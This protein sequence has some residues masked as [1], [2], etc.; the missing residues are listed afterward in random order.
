M[1]PQS[2]LPRGFDIAPI[3]HFLFGR[4][5]QFLNS[6]KTIIFVANISSDS[7]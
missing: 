6:S 2:E 4:R 5:F 1:A 7:S 3:H